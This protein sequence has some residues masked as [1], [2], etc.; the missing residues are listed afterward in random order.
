MLDNGRMAVLPHA[1]MARAVLRPLRRGRAGR[2]VKRL[3]RRAFRT[4]RSSPPVVQLIVGAI[5]LVTVWAP[6]NWVV[7]VVRKPAEV[8]GTVSASRAKLPA[9]T[10]EQYGPLF[11][12]H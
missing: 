11:D 6:V 10:W 3:G 4:I 1:L 5:V 9:Q 8:F 7:Q 2:S 12:A